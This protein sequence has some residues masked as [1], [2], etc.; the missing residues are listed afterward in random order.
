MPIIA[1]AVP[2]RS[3][4]AMTFIEQFPLD[5]ELADAIEMAPAKAAKG[6][7]LTGRQQASVAREMPIVTKLWHKYRDERLENRVKPRAARGRRLPD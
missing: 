4:R 2:A 5:L 1:I 7:Q 3:W 6:Y